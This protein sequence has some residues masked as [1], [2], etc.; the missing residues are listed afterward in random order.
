MLIKRRFLLIAIASVFSLVLWLGWPIYQFY[1]H[2]GT[3]PL[4]PWGFLRLPP[5]TP[6]RQMVV[7]SDLAP[8]ADEALSQLAAHR[9][10]IGAPG[11]SAAVALDGELIWTGVAGWAD[12]ETKRP[13]TP[14]TQF[15]IGST[16]KS[17]TMT[18]LA[19]LVQTGRIDLDSAI[20]NYIP[21]LPNAAWNPLTPRQ[22]ASHMAG[23]PEHK[24]IRDWLGVYH[25]MALR[26]HYH[27]EFD[28][29][30]VF[31]DMPL[32]YN[33]GSKFHYSSYNTVLLS[34][35]L[36]A[37]ENQS[38]REVMEQQ[39]FA[40]LGMTNTAAEPREPTSTMTTFYWRDD[41]QVRPWR[42]VNLSHRLAGGGFISTPT[43]LVKL[44]SAWL[45]NNFISGTTRDTFWEPQRTSDGKVNPQNYA[46]GWRVHEID[47]DG[48]H[49]FIQIN[50]GGVSRGSQC[51][52]MIIPSTRMV[53]ALA[54]NSRTEE[55]WDF[56]KVSF[57][58]AKLFQP[59]AQHS[60]KP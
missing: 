38:F 19:R 50:H 37:A 51:W 13:V 46:L 5:E 8:I 60:V 17:L 22:L 6:A 18:A 34:T 25:V 27:R 57:D 35:V 3:L 39:V 16:S 43:D 9:Q 11:I 4:P 10:S 48:E 29:L 44:G 30:E 23:L 42:K 36:A 59:V 2:K 55:F 32:L 47:M 7:T 24:E 54:I 28:S 20:V 45:D 56:A 26:K 49:V 21:A 14:E 53:I 1:A 52:L 12:I 58:L 33:P 15:R 41:E 40:P 31:D